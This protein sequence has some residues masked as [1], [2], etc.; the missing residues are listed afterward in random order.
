MPDPNEKTKN[1]KNIKNKHPLYPKVTP[2][3]N[4]F[5]KNKINNNNN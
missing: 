1:D 2:R 5:L 3:Y 4:I